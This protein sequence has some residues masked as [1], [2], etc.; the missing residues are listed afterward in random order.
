MGKKIGIGVGAFFGVI[1]IVVIVAV[2]MLTR[3]PSAPPAP[4]PLPPSASGGTGQPPPSLPEQLK[5][6]EEAVKTGQPQEV[7]ITITEV[8]LNDEINKILKPG[9]DLGGIM[10]QE[11]TAYLRQGLLQVNLKVNMPPVPFA[12]YPT[13]KASIAVKDGKLAVT[14]QSLDIGTVGLPDTF[15]EQLNALMGNELGKIQ[16]AGT[17]VELKTVTVGDG[18]LTVTG[19]TKPK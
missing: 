12:L 10:V 1:I 16:L 14:I 13:I 17:G 5:K 6:V 15:R 3:A 11:A 18:F 9:T 4:P 8:M 7:K 19:M 2:V